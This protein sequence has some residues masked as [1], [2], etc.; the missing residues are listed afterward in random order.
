MNY[1]R[2]EI[3][4]IKGMILN[5]HFSTNEEGGL[6]WCKRYIREFRKDFPGAVLKISIFER[7]KTKE[8]WKDRKKPYEFKRTLVFKVKDELEGMNDLEIKDV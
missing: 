3:K 4:T 8:I 6:R 1:F 5:T 7:E 2:L